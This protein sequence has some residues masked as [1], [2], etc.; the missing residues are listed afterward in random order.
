MEKEFWLEITRNDYSVPQHHTASELLPELLTNLGSI[1]SDLRESAYTILSEWV[2]VQGLY[3]HEEL[4]VISAQL[5][6]NL[7]QG[8]GEQGTD[9]VFLRSFS[10]LVLNNVVDYDNAH[11]FL[12][13]QEVLAWL[14]ETLAYYQE[15]CDLRGYVPVKGWAHSVAH[16][17]D[18]LM[19]FARNRYVR[20]AELERILHVI[21][22]RVTSPVSAVFIDQEDER[23][24]VVVLTALRRNLLP[25]PSL[26]TWVQSI[27]QPE[28]RQSWRE[29]FSDGE[30][31]IAFTH[32]RTF[33]RSLYFQLL[34]T[35]EPPTIEAALREEILQALRSIDLGFYQ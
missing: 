25:L 7:H 5:R 6:T 4:R 15:E 17:A 31:N 14:E 27:V 1:D 29:T 11:P 33:L 3:M 32:V 26:Q 10:L 21:A 20:Q 13:E 34:L 18:L 2:E 19:A 35:K 23:L 9:S 22:W 24:C 8:L 28:G 12:Q 16:G 30:G